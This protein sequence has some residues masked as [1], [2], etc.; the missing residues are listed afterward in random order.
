MEIYLHSHEDVTWITDLA[1]TNDMTKE[2]CY[3][4]LKRDF[5]GYHFCLPSKGMYNT[6]GVLGTL[7]SGQFRDY[8][9]ETGTP[10]FL[11]YQLK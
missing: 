8:W 5:D 10:S 2:E 9:F 4:R 3:E 6:F 11:F 7:A 1:V